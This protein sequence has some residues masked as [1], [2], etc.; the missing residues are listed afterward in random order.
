MELWLSGVSYYFHEMDDKP[1]RSRY[2]KI[3][4]GSR[5]EERVTGCSR[6]KD[7]IGGMGRRDI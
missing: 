3:E 7:G 4:T 2:E 6:A 1:I 5:Q